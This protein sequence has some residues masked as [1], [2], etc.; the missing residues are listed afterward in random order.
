[1]ALEADINEDGGELFVGEDKI[2]DLEVLQDDG[3]TPQDIA[4]WSITFDVRLTDKTSTALL[5]KS[6]TVTGTYSATRASNT[7]RARVTLTD[8]ELASPT[9]SGRTYRHSW[10]RLTDG[11]ETILAYGDFRMQ[12]ATQV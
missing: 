3:A 1:M 2:L 4:G 10:K 6:A 11:S 12:R 8:T 9:F 7:Q 5:S